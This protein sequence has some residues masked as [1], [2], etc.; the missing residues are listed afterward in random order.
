MLDYKGQNYT[1]TKVTD[2][3][4]LRNTGKIVLFN[5]D[6]AIYSKNANITSKAINQ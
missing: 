2:F 4:V 5:D 3:P 1:Q 6:D